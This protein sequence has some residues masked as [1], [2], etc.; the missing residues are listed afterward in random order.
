MPTQH[1]IIPDYLAALT[2]DQRATADALR[3]LA[4]AAAPGLTERIKWNA[5]SFV[6]DGEDRIT[7]G[8]DKSGRIR[9]ILHRGVKPKEIAGFSFDAPADLV[10]WAARDRGVMTFASQAE[11]ETRAEEIGDVF[12]RW[13]EVS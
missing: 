5:P 6:Q 13:L 4:S 11:V 9:V 8:Q 10:Q 3:A 1:K 12:R 7:L 2:P